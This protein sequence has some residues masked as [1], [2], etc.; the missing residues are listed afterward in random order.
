MQD[1]VEHRFADPFAERSAA[2]ITK[3]LSF[4]FSYR[5]LLEGPGFGTRRSQMLDAFA[6]LLVELHIAGCFW[7]DCSLSNV[8]YRFDAQAVDTIRSTPRP[9]TCATPS[10]TASAPKTSPS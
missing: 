2:L 8:L 1:I 9:R 6:G 4:S 3:Y 7:G 10:A 5:E